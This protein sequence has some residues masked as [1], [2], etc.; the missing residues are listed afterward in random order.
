METAEAKKEHAIRLLN[1]SWKDREIEV[2]EFQNNQIRALER[3]VT[4]L[5]KDLEQA[6]DTISV[7]ENEKSGL[8]G[9]VRHMGSENSKLLHIKASLIDT[10]KEVDQEIPDLRFD[11]TPNSGIHKRLEGDTP[12]NKYVDGK[13]FFAEAR[14]RLSFEMFSKFLSY[15][16]RINEKSITKERAIAEVR[17]IFG[18]QNDDLYQDFTNLLARR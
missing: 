7:L 1:E 12:P 14:S 11:A 9:T 5:R 3:E 10:L 6:K 13:R 4:K 8:E 15:V 2:L 17:D 16:K 18:G